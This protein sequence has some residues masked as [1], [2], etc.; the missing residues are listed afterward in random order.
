MYASARLE[1]TTFRSAGSYNDQCTTPPLS[2]FEQSSFLKNPAQNGQ[3][4]QYAFWKVSS[5][6]LSISSYFIIYLQC[7][8]QSLCKRLILLIYV[9]VEII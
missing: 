4:F 3:I 6:L 2:A 9:A 1:P 5:F 8:T 7:F